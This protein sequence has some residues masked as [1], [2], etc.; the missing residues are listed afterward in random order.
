[1][2]AKK[3]LLPLLLHLPRRAP[4]HPFQIPS[5][6]I[7]DARIRSFFPPWEHVGEVL[8]HP[9]NLGT[10]SQTPG[11]NRSGSIC[12][13]TR[14]QVPT[15]SSPERG[16]K[17]A[18]PSILLA[19][20]SVRNIPSGWLHSSMNFSYCLL[21][22]IAPGSIDSWLQLLSANVSIL[23]RRLRCGDTWRSGSGSAEDREPGALCCGLH[24]RLATARPL[25]HSRV[26]S[27]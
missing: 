24:Q 7:S 22:F 17:H 23:W 11:T 15:L 2:A 3:V 26:G 18:G 6:A 27:P 8:W 10:I 16:T 9:L 4:E 20:P 13:W 21:T 1:M 25:A 5:L 19:P 12:G 14:S